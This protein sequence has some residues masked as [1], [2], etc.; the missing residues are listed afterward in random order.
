MVPPSLERIEAALRRPAVAVALAAALLAAL[1]FATTASATTITGLTFSPVTATAGAT[2]DYTVTFTASAS[3]QLA[4]TLSDYVQVTFPSGFTVPSSPSISFDN[5]KFTGCTITTTSGITTGQDVEADLPAGCHLA[6]GA[7]GKIT[8]SGITNPSGGSYS[9]ASVLTSGDTTTVNAANITITAATSTTVSIGPASR[10]V[11]AGSSTEQAGEWQTITLTAEDS[12]GNKVDTFS[13]PHTVTFSGASTSSTGT[14]PTV[15]DDTGAY[16]PFGAATPLT[17]SHGIAQPT[18]K[19]YT[20]ET[21]TITAAS[22]ADSIAAAPGDALTVTVTPGAPARLKLLTAPGG[23]VSGQPFTTQPVLEVLDAFGNPDTSDSSTVVVA[24]VPFTPGLVV[25]G[26]GAAQASHGIVTFS[27]YGLQTGGPVTVTFVPFT[28]GISSVSADVTVARLPAT[29]S[30]TSS[31][32]AVAGQPVTLTATLDPAD[33]SGTVSFGDTSVD[34]IGGRADYTYTP[35]KAG[36]VTITADYGGNSLYEPAQASV[37]LTVAG[38]PTTIAISYDDS[39]HTLRATVSGSLAGSTAPPSGTVDFHALPALWNN[40]LDTEIAT[41]TLDRGVAKV[42]GT[43]YTLPPGRYLVEADYEPAAGTPYAASPSA[44]TPVTVTKYSSA[45]RLAAPASIDLGGTLTLTAHLTPAELVGKVSFSAQELAPDAGPAHVIG[46]V[47]IQDGTAT[48]TTAAARSAGV[49]TLYTA[50]WADSRARYVAATDAA[51]VSTTRIATRLFA[52]NC[53]PG[54]SSTLSCPFRSNDQTVAAGGKGR[55]WY[56]TAYTG[57]DGAIGTQNG[58]GRTTAP[59][60]LPTGRLA[61]TVAVE[62]GGSTIASTGLP[63][64]SSYRQ[65]KCS[66][67]PDSSGPDTN[68]PCNGI[69]ALAQEDYD[70]AVRHCTFYCSLINHSEFYEHTDSEEPLAAP[71]AALDLGPLLAKLP[72]GTT[73]VTFVFTP[74]DDRYRSARLTVAVPQPGIPLAS[75]AATGKDQTVDLGTVGASI[76]GI[77]ELLLPKLKLPAGALPAGAAIAVRQPALAHENSFYGRDGTALDVTITDASGHEL[78]GPFSPP[79][80]LTF[81]ILSPASAYSPVTPSV[82]RNGAQV[83]LEKYASEAAFLSSGAQD[84]YVDGVMCD[85][86]QCAGDVVVYTRHLTTFVLTRRPVV[87]AGNAVLRV[88]WRRLGIW[89]S[90]S[91]RSTV[92]IALFQKT[93]TG[94]RLVETLGP[95]RLQPGRHIIRFRLSKALTATKGLRAVLLSRSPAGTVALRRP[96]IRRP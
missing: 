6:N 95:R 93:K 76:Y 87:H 60:T 86:G 63:A 29:L 34:V 42:A 8:I 57:R 2:S 4:A 51:T 54:A 77:A 44:P 48:L 61:G 33:A 41:T 89:V 47:R 67:Q 23:A 17:F 40:G 14:T 39:T 37:S 92:S 84:G 62:A 26:L 90:P 32:D 59:L 83:P 21:A 25:L 50:A 53:D 96:L 71:T 24:S 36:P 70:E 66:L 68:D 94:Q 16:Q 79:L 10:L 81:P 64:S 75:T 30:L 13:G 91:V 27:G 38:S 52:M 80:A 74:A 12:A 43:G 85:Q 58:Y 7:T 73:N 69:D 55:F 49:K 88:G 15:Q 11:V 65:K 9:G 46:T 19:L 1:V 18:M 82:V 28:S 31:G 20:V 22:S 3:G 35:T 56:V 78:H 5:T 72:R 45:L